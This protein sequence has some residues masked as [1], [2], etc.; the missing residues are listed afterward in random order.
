MKKFFSAVFPLFYL[1]LSCFPLLPTRAHAAADAYACILQENAYFYAS[2]SL[3]DGLFVLPQTY[4]VKVLLTGDEFTKVEYLTD[5][6]SSQ[7]IVGYCQTDDLTF[8]DYT[9]QTPYLHHVFDV[10]YTAE[11]ASGENDFFHKIT[12][13]CTYYGAYAVGAKT[14][15]YVLQGTQFGYVP[16]PKDF[17]YPKSTE[18][19]EHTNGTAGE[20]PPTGEASTNP[21][22]I[23]IL[24]LLCLL[25]PLLAALV[26]RSSKKHPYEFDDSST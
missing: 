24:V 16:L 15:A 18:H 1:F 6:P 7:K 22:Q 3:S 21:A 8:V 20:T 26:L 17:S 2:E 19:A 25:V 9:P 23:A 10:T 12:V 13:S 11:H 4:Y 14:Y 5:G